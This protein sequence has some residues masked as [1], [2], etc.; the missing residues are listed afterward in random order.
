MRCGLTEYAFLCTVHSQKRENI[1]IILI[2]KST[3]LSFVSHVSLD[4]VSTVF[5]VREIKAYLYCRWYVALK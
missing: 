3:E 5:F 2:K 1:D 4:V